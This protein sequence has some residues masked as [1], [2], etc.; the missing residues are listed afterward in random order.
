MWSHDIAIV[1]ACI[2]VFAGSIPVSL[3]VRPALVD[4][5]KTVEAMEL[6][7]ERGLSGLIFEQPFVDA[8]LIERATALGLALHCGRTNKPADIARVLEL[9]PTSICSDFPERVL[10]LAASELGAGYD[11]VGATG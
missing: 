8:A 11:R 2:E 9:G 4:H 6:A 10:L 1:R 7:F 5:W 3:I